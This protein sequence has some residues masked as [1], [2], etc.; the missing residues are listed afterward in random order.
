MPSCF[1][2]L[3]QALTAPLQTNQV[4]VL[5]GGLEGI[6]GGLERL[7]EGKI[8]ATKLVVRPQETP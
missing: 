8:S 4:E 7:R 3:H 1:T 6:V 5:P 2:P